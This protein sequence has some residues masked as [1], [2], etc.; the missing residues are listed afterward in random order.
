[1]ETHVENKT[2]L[3]TQANGA[4]K[5]KTKI[6]TLFETKANG[7]PKTAHIKIECQ[8][9]S[10]GRLAASPDMHLKNRNKRNSNI[11]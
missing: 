8:T 6:K 5:T 3:E 10:P 1:L 9:T 7:A 4:P 11:K 2:L